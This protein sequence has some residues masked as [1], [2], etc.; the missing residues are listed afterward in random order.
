MML[1]MEN[2]EENTPAKVPGSEG[3][4]PEKPQEQNVPAY[5]STTEKRSA[6]K[7]PQVENLNHQDGLKDTLKDAENTDSDN[8]QT[9]NDEALFGRDTN[10]DL[11]AG[12]RDRDEGEEEK[13]IRT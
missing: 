4:N 8:P 3:Y 9:K 5:H 6:E 12:Q 10:A 11:G 2:R 7:L 13:I 1:N